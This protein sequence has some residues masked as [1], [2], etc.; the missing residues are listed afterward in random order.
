MT[1]HT[2]AMLTNS[3]TLLGIIDLVTNIHP[4]TVR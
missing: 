1:T 3:H 2:M 4:T